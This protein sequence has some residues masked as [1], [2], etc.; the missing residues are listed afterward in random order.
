MSDAREPVDCVDPLIDAAK[1]RI[2]WVFTVF[3]A[4]PFGMVRLGPNTDPE[5]TWDAGY[6]YGSSTISC[7][8]HMHAWQLAGVPVMPVSGSCTGSGG[9]GEY[10]SRFRHAT[11]VARPGYYAVTLDDYGIRAELTATNR[12]GFHCYTFPGGAERRFLF[13]LGATL[14][15]AEMSGAFVHRVDAAEIEGYAE[16]E[17][18]R[19][20]SKRCRVYF[21]ARFDRPFAALD[22]W[23][24]A[25]AWQYTWHVPHDIQSLIGLMGGRPL[26]RPWFYHREMVRGG[27]LVLELGGEPNRSWDSKPEDAPPSG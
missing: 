16:N 27:R 26:G 2:R 3:T 21:V 1:P 6:R 24:E 9:F 20:R 11:E 8:S 5:G 25:N 13:D 10:A 17:T 14:G 15:P 12:V 22:G 23:C 4:R 7:F 18:T 19:R